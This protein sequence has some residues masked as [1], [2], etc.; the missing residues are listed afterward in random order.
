MEAANIMAQ[1]LAPLASWI[2]VIFLSHSSM[3]HSKLA[4]KNVGYLLLDCYADAP[5]ENTHHWA[6]P[7]LDKRAPHGGVLGWVAYKHQI[8]SHSSSAQG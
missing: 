2:A 6:I 3:V 5:K 8:F 4:K 7:P 1:Q